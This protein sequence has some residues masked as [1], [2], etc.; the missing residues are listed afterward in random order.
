MKYPIFYFPEPNSFYA[1]NAQKLYS[2]IVSYSLL[3]LCIVLSIISFIILRNYQTYDLSTNSKENWVLEC[4]F[5]F[6]PFSIVIFLVYPSFSLLY[7]LNEIH[8][9]EVAV[10]IVGHQWYWGYEVIGFLL[11]I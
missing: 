8:D 10:K 3:I 4:L 7:G 11:F 9:P 5:V 1:E 6:F 2:L